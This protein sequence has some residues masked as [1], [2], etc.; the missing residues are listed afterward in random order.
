M[1]KLYIKFIEWNEESL[2]KACDIAESLG[3]EK[4]K[5]AWSLDFEWTWLLML[6]NNWTY[7]TALHNKKELINIWYR[8][9]I[10]EEEQKKENEVYVIFW[11]N[12]TPTKTHFSL[13]SAEDEAQRLCKKENKPFYVCKI[14]AKYENVAIL[15]DNINLN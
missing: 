4:N 8:E 7:Y 2:K 14:L 13:S 5:T 15:S 6:N 1:E 11:G 3:Y 9:Y 12:K 10:Q